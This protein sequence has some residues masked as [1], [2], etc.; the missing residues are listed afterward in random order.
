MS[1]SHLYNLKISPD[2][3]RGNLSVASESLNQQNKSGLETKWDL[4]LES[5]P[6]FPWLG[7]PGVEN[8]AFLGKGKL[9]GWQAQPPWSWPF[10]ACFRLGLSLPLRS[11]PRAGSSAHSLSK[12][13]PSHCRWPLLLLPPSLYHHHPALSGS[14]E[15]KDWPAGP[16]VVLHTMAL[17]VT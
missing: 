10:L 3:Q 17:K 4:F 13:V 11:Q 5:K 12:W 8:K 7:C 15:R 1:R 2:A 14:G 6:Y 9:T 16:G